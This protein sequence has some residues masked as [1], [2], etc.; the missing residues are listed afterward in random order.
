MRNLHRTFVASLAVAAALTLAA[1]A[2]VRV[3]SSLE[4]G[5][6]F[7]HYKSYAWAAADRFSTGDARLD[8]NEFFENRL[9]T[10]ADRLL[11]THGLERSTPATADIVIHYHANVRETIDVNDLDRRYGYCDTCNATIYNA[12]TITLDFV[13]SHTNKLVWRGWSEGSLDGIDSQSMIEARVD[14]AVT[15]ILAKLPPHM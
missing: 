5:M 7:T 4:R 10:T 6:D 11:A 13:D 2:P 8:N 3:N 14:D 12:G 9:K 1:C 15:R